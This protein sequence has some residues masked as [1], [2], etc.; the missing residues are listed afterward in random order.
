MEVS[1]VTCVH[2]SRE[3]VGG[4][5]LSATQDGVDFVPPQE[6]KTAGF[7]QKEGRFA[8]DNVHDNP[9]ADDLYST[10]LKDFGKEVLQRQNCI[11]FFGGKRATPKRE[12]IFGP[13]GSP[14]KGILHRMLKDLS[15]SPEFANH[16][17]KVTSYLI[18]NDKVIV[19]LFKLDND[20]GVMTESLKG[21]PIISGLTE[22]TAATGAQ[23]EG[24]CKVAAESV[25]KVFSDVWSMPKTDEP[26]PHYKPEN[27][28]FSVRIFDPNRETSEREDGTFEA[29]H[30]DVEQNSLTIVALGDSERPALCGIEQKTLAQY[31]DQQKTLSA[32][33]GVLG[34][35][36]CKRLRVPFGKCRLMHL[37]K[38][39]FNAEKNNPYNE[40][41]KPTASL[42]FLSMLDDARNAEESYHSL[43]FGKRIINVIG[44]SGVG[45][46]SR[47]L[48]VERWRLEQD[49]IELKDELDIVKMVHGYKPAIY[50]QAKPVANIK[51]EEQKRI[52]KII[53]QRDDAKNVE[54]EA[55]RTKA[56]EEAKQYIEGEQRKSNQNIAKLEALLADKTQQN[57]KLNDQHSTKIKEYE[58][59]L[60]KVRKKRVEEEEK[61]ER[62]KKDVTEIETQLQARH[63]SIAKQKEQLEMLS[64][65][66][67]KGTEMIIES[68]KKAKDKRDKAM[69]ERR[70]MRQK[71]LAEIKSANDKIV[72]SVTDLE[73]VKKSKKDI[74]KLPED[75]DADT[76]DSIKEDVK[77]IDRFVQQMIS[78]DDEAPPAAKQEKTED[79]R[80]QLMEY[81]TTERLRLEKKLNEEL[82]RREHLEKAAT[83]YRSRLNEQQNRVKKDQMSDA[84]KK[85][86]HLESLLEQVVQYLE[87]GCRMTKIRGSERKRYLFVSEDRKRIHSCEVDDEGMPANKRRPT[88]T[89]YFRDIK[90]IILGQYTPNF[91]SFEAGRSQIT[92]TSDLIHDVDGAYNR[93]PTA[94]VTAE[95]MSSYF[96]RSFSLEFKKGKTWDLIAETDSDFEAWVVVLQRL[97][98]SKDEWRKVVDIRKGGAIDPPPTMAWGEG[99]DLVN[100]Q[101]RDRLMAEEL[102]LCADNHVTP[103]QYIN[104][105][106]Q[107]IHKA[108]LGFVTVYDVRTLSTL[109]LLRSR[110]VHEFF[111]AKKVIPQ[112]NPTDIR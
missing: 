105:K 29:H 19:D 47:D 45:P 59:Q 60:E 18:G 20:S 108:Q 99:L 30:Q 36:R 16:T 104:I 62:L 12:L 63:E 90:R 66:H 57:Q 64:K 27:I 7:P 34:A 112:P 87:H 88:T 84:I 17:C 24:L 71:W 107:I 67:T 33:V 39:A 68:R 13:E 80:K 100:R 2:S 43:T 8:F 21:P 75:A 79:T 103:I 55:L 5:C 48:A 96:Y 94:T 69:G 81:F 4:K 53:K 70:E 109:D 25:R 52:A 51:E 74:L 50:N 89:A 22:E 31:E 83:Q 93:T 111:L 44:G 56:A 41:N 65:D 86:K 28:I 10:Y 37:L 49:I 23:L 61:T 35:I 101:G 91:K 97:L 6:L 26:F 40:E 77:S 82:D 32:V 3:A 42:L 15:S 95:N 58:R 1:L 38:R 76:E 110:V 73:G 14:Q 46:A 92:R 106:A 78:L 11:V 102:K 72:Q 9:S 98:L 85:E 54:L